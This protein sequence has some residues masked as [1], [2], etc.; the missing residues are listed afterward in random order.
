MTPAK[1]QKDKVAS[2]DSTSHGQRAT[3]A[4]EENRQQEKAV[5]LE[6]VVGPQMQVALEPV[7]DAQMQAAL[8]SV[9]LAALAELDVTIVTPKWVQLHAAG[10]GGKHFF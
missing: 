4:Q 1:G 7:T 8:H 10:E 9:H 3:S 5:A 2:S 6:P